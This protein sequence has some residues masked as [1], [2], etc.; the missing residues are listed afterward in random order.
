MTKSRKA[1][2]M[3]TKR[4]TTEAAPVSRLLRVRQAAAY[5]GVGISTLNYWRSGGGGPR[6]I[7]IGGKSGKIVMYDLADLDVWLNANK[8][9]TTAE[10]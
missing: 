5:L 8:Y 1:K 7:K 2:A 10:L 3:L 4:K 6:F 9:A